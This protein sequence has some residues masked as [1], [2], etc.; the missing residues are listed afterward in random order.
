MNV[1]LDKALPLASPWALEFTIG[2][3]AYAVRALTVGDVA[4]LINVKEFS[5]REFVNLIEDW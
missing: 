2:G 5:D 4:K 3:K 1:E